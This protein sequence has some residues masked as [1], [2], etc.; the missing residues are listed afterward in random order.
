M[1]KAQKSIGIA[2]NALIL[3]SILCWGKTR[4][5]YSS[6]GAR[7][8][9]DSINISQSGDTV[10]VHN[11][12]YYTSSLGSAWGMVVNRSIVLMSV[13]PESASACTLSGLG[14]NSRVLACTSCIATVQGFTITK[15]QTLLYGGGGITCYKS[16]ATVQNC[17]ITD[18]WCGTMGGGVCF[19]NST[20]N[21]RNN[22]IN[23]NYGDFGG[24]IG[25]FTSEVIVENNILTSNRAVLGGG[26]GIE[27]STASRIESNIITDNKSEGDGG[28][29]NLEST[30][31]GVVIFRDNL[32]IG[33]T[34]SDCGGGMNLR[35]VNG[36]DARARITRCVLASNVSNGSGG[37]IYWNTGKTHIDSC[38][39][40]DNGAPASR[41]S[42]AFY[43]S[44]NDTFRISNSH[45]YYNSFQ[46]DTEA[47][48]A[49]TM[50]MPF[51]GNYWWFQD[52]V[53]I[54][55][56]I[57]GPATISPFRTT[58]ISSVPGEPTGVDSVRNYASNWTT[59]VNILLS[60]D[61][62]FLKIYGRDRN[63]ALREVAIALLKSRIY[64]SGIAVSLVETNRNSGIYQGK[65][66]VKEATGS[67]TIRSDDIRQTIRVNPGCDTIVI[68]THIDTTKKF[69][70]FYRP[71][72][73][74]SEETANRPRRFSSIHPNPTS[75][76]VT[77]NRR[78][79]GTLYN[80]SGQR[81]SD[82][83]CSRVD[84]ARLTPGI[85]FLLTGEFR[86]GC[87]KI[88]KID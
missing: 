56:I 52:S 21:L 7:A 57:S 60:P 85:Y 22:V 43:M 73:Y 62:L 1:F 16:T 69:L 45:L 32:I 46:P 14:G 10:V 54:R 81:I 2:L 33:N 23:N 59:I 58:F 53:S 78:L 6:G 20:G 24:G 9:Q 15:G 4:H 86:S 5:V 63:A 12:I 50:T 61:T 74:V 36:R 66:Y 27:Y 88:I 40:V 31:S 19:N 75:G 64:P 8:I 67:D 35:Y 29:I 3:I 37:A 47:L 70:V 26:L 28:G 80:A 30:Y 18:N 39:I 83:N 72:M 17:I 44:G 79:R 49:T 41:T 87:I 84:L 82:I 51:Q 55:N 65:A 68:S 38:M 77:F 71:G 42:G 76:Y 34:A 13:R 11:G 25:I 48:N